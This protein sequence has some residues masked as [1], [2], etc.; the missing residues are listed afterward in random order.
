MRR[1]CFPDHTCYSR[2]SYPFSVRKQ[3]IVTS[4]HVADYR[5]QLSVRIG[6]R[7]PCTMIQ[8][9][10]FEGFEV[11]LLC[12]KW[13]VIY[14]MCRSSKKGYEDQLFDSLTSSASLP[15]TNHTDAASLGKSNND[16]SWYWNSTHHSFN[17][18][19]SVRTW[20]AAITGRVLYTRICH[21]CNRPR[22]PAQPINVDANGGVWR[23]GGDDDG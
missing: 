20:H 8:S 7:A 9:F 4:T 10:R 3:L 11:N 21:S 19:I 23:Y 13:H 6:P 2:R 1:H 18:V 14:T 17:A 16:T 15:T 12:H 5:C 22:L